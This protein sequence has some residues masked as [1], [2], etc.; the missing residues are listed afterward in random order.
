[1][2]T[3]L[4]FNINAELYENRFDE[5]AIKFA[6]EKVFS[7]VGGGG[8]DF[9]S[10]AVSFLQEGNRPQG[11]R[12]MPPHQL[13]YGQD[14]RCICSMGYVNGDE[15]QPALGLEVPAEEIGERARS[16]IGEIAG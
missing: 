12:D 6:G 7:E 2:E 14:W 13:L 1:M 10:E 4:S 11:W 5:L 9:L 15:E 8:G 3:R 16:Y